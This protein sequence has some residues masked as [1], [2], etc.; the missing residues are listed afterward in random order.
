MIPAMDLGTALRIALDA[1]RANKVRGALTTLGII[2]GIVAVV[3]T[4]TAANGLRDRFRESFSAVGTDV[5][6]VSRV[7]WVQ[8]DDF[9]RFR[10]RPNIDLRE[11]RSLEQKLRG[12]ALVNPS[13]EGRRD[14]KYRSEVMENVSIIGTT[15]KQGRMSSAQPQTGRFLIP[16]DVAFK[17][18]VCVIG[19]D[20][21]DGLFGSADPM[22]KLIKIGRAE[23]RIVGVME[24]QGGSFLGGPNFDRQIYV[25]ISSYVNAFSGSHGGEDVNVAVKA[26]TQE[27]MGDLEY[28]VI[29]EMRKI[30][31]LRPSQP[32][33]FSINKLDTLVGT[34]NNVMGVVLLVG[35]LVTGISLFVGAIGVM[36]IM[37]VSVTERTRE[38]GIRKAIGAT[39]RSILLQFLFEST[40]ICLL[41]GGVGISLAWIL[42]AVVNATL[43]PATISIPILVIAVLVSMVV[44]VVA[45]VAPAYRGA[46]MDPIEALRYE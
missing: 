13:I 40:A 16:S 10:N 36:N 5:L 21:K 32:D 43:M 6:Y 23:F 1:I 37:F 7:P 28:E 19:T 15:D 14:I 24:K 11:A 39:R 34:F 38:I 8:M 2:I 30:R 22:N 31:V 20:V 17:K 46:K 9:F 3:L 4:M 27:A 41:G 29:G 45:G 26:P 18:R 44:G 12:R 35:L 42:T 33:N 25:P